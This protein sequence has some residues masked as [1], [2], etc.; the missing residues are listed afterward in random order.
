MFLIDLVFALLIA[1]LIAV[2]LTAVFGWRHPSRRQEEATLPGAF[3][4]FLILFFF[5][6]A[7]GAWI[8]P[9]GPVLWSSAWLPFLLVGVVIGLF[10]LAVSE[11]PRP[12]RQRAVQKPAPGE[13]DPVP[14]RVILY[15]AVF[16]ILL[17]VLL[18]VVIAA[19]TA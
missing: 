5:I 9:F 6:W 13:T 11:P 4:L 15:G 10:L 1:F 2:L 7:G 8:G 3:F 18:A 17:L 19:Y 16:W 14:P 12:P